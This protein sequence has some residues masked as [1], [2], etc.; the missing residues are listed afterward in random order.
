MTSEELIEVAM[1]I[2]VTSGAAKSNYMEAI[3]EAKKGNYELANKRIE[4]AKEFLLK[5]HRTQTDLISK[6]MSG[7]NDSQV[8]LLMVHAQD[9]LTSS[10]ILK[11][12]SKE[13]IE[14]HRKIGEK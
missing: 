4:E 8:N 11:D 6:A 13:I 5:A 3:S 14:L 1:E 12:L 7:E 9:H 10:Q 2:I